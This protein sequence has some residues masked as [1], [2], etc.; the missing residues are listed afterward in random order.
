MGSRSRSMQARTPLACA[1]LPRSPSRPSETSIAA[2]ATRAARGPA[3]AAARRAGTGA[4][5]RP[6]HR[7]SAR[8]ACSSVEPGRRHARRTRHEDQVAGLRARA[9]Q[10]RGRAARSPAPRRDDERPG[11]GV[12][13]DERDAVALGQRVQSLCES[14]RATARRRCGS[15]SDSNA[16]AGSAPIAAR[17]LRLTA[18]AWWP[19][20]AAGVPAQEMPAFDQ[21]VGG[22]H[23]RLPGGGSSNAASSPTP[24]STSARAVC[25]RSSGR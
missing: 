23:Q 25:A 7:T 13:A 1:S 18:S 6:S 10:R 5:G 21:R 11:H 3:R 16:Q 8:P 22:R 17:S 14:R 15:D 19:S 2:V 4:R 24:S 20:A 12:A 9:T